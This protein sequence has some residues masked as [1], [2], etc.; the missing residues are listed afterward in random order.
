MTSDLE[1]STDD[2]YAAIRRLWEAG[3]EGTTDEG[4]AAGRSVSDTAIAEETGLALPVV[5][6]YLDNADG[7]QFVVDRDGE[8]RTVTAIL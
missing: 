3:Q 1:I 8:T 6:E 4:G 7:E 2:V 5:R